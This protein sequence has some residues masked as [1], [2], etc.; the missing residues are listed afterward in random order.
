MTPS[1]IHLLALGLSLAGCFGDDSGDS[2]SIQPTLIAVQPDDFLGNVPCSPDPGALQSYIATFYDVESAGEAPAFG[3]GIPL[4]SSPPVDCRRS[5]GTQNVTDA[6]HYAVEIHAFD[7]PAC[8]RD[9]E[10]GCI[11]ALIP[12]TPIAADVSGNVVDPR[13]TTA[14]GRGDRQAVLPVDF[15]TVY[16]HDC[17]PLVLDPATTTSAIR[18]AVD[19]TLGALACGSEPDS[20]DHFTVI[21]EEPTLVPQ[22]AVCGD[23]LEFAA[24]SSGREYAFRVEAYEPSAATPRWA[25]SCRATAVAGAQVSATCSPLTS[26][27]AILLEVPAL[28]GSS[29]GDDGTVACECGADF[30][31]VAVTLPESLQPNPE[32]LT[33]QACRQTLSIAAEAGSYTFEVELR[34][35]AGD[36]IRFTC[37]ANVAPLA[38]ERAVCTPVN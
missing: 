20:V 23:V 16:I 3:S 11:Q 30:A 38:D 12:G 21:P 34:P 36:P 6:H 18:L 25:S 29:C 26:Q 24:S 1:R 7:R 33:G 35:L 4:F 17:E 10:E 27:G 8:D 28:L 14:C 37:Q 19:G 31:S 13:W 5:V 22:T 9:A 32:P 2:T 15:T